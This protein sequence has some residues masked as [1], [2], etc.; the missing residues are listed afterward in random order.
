MAAPVTTEHV[1]KAMPGQPAASQELVATPARRD[2]AEASALLGAEPGRIAFGWHP[3]ASG[4][5]ADQR[6][7]NRRLKQSRPV[8]DSARR[9]GVRALQGH[10]NDHGASMALVLGVALELVFLVIADDV[11]HGVGPL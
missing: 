1:S 4:R 6:D 2:A 7:A 3:L 11:D 10:A 5:H 8:S 9:L